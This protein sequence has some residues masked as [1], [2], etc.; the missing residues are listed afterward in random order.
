[1]VATPSPELDAEVRG[2]KPMEPY[3]K[4]PYWDNDLERPPTSNTER[5]LW[6]AQWGG[7]ACLPR[8]FAVTAL[9]GGI[10]ASVGPSSV[11]VPP[12]GAPTPREAEAAVEAARAA[13]DGTFGAAPRPLG[14][15]CGEQARAAHTAARRARIARQAFVTYVS[16]DKSAWYVEAVR[17]MALLVSETCVPEERGRPL[18]VIALKDGVSPETVALWGR[19]G[20]RVVE[21]DDEFDMEIRATQRFRGVMAK[22]SG[23]G[24]A[25]SEFDK[26]YQLDPDHIV[27]LRDE[28]GQ[29]SSC[30]AFDYPNATVGGAIM[31]EPMTGSLVYSPDDGFLRSMVNG[32]RAMTAERKATGKEIFLYDQDSMDVYLGSTSGY[33]Q[34]PY[35]FDGYRR[36]ASLRTWSRRSEAA[37]RW[38]RHA[39]HVHFAGKKPWDAS[40]AGG[41]SEQREFF[42][43]IRHLW[44]KR[45]KADDKLQIPPWGR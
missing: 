27:R 4:H 9:S 24:G 14:G 1:M 44:E 25:L 42:D 8:Q 28:P 29:A 37:A 15:A 5:R 18:V 39:P 11:L 40:L 13:A 36:L 30:Q 32:A 45:G 2:V 26:V 22:L 33:F 41:A 16:S 31:S 23:F 10:A 43:T 19:E 20:I 34:L 17:A 35:W 7:W 12:P 3:R 38:W 21:V 6:A